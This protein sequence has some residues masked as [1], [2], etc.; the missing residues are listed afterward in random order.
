[1]F[2]PKIFFLV[3][4]IYGKWGFC[5][6]FLF[7]NNFEMSKYSNSED[8]SEFRIYSGNFGHLGQI[9]V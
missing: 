7:L 1:M 5:D 8:D 2:L 6:L 3:F 9:G 4:V